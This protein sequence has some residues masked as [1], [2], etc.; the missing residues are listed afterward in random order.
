M[1][2][3]EQVGVNRQLAGRTG[4]RISLYSLISVIAMVFIRQSGKKPCN[5]FS[6]IR[7]FSINGSPVRNKNNV[8]TVM[9]IL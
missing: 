9:M 3:S 6:Q 2:Y 8:I 5:V 4:D 1:E 7:K